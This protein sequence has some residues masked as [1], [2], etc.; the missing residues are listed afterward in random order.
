MQLTHANLMAECRGCVARLPTTPGGRTV[1]YLPS[2]HIADRWSGHYQSSLCLGFEITSIADLAQ[3]PAVLADVRPT[4]FGAVPRVWE[5]MKAALEAAGLTDPAAVP[6]EIRAGARAKLGLDASEWFCAGAAPT[7]RDV[8]EF[9]AALGVPIAELY[10]MS[11]LSCCATINPPDAIRLGTCGPPI[12][13]VELRL[14]DD[15]ELLVRGP[16][17]MA[18]YRGA[19]ELTAETIDDDGW[20]HTGDVARIDDDGYLTIIDRKKELIINAA[21]KNMS[22]A[23]IESVLKAASPI[24]GQAVAIGD[25]RPY[26]VALVVLDPD[27]AGAFARE[28]GVQDTSVAALAR[29]PVIREAVAHAVAAANTHLARVE[30]IKR[31]AILDREWVAGGPELTPTMKLQ[32]RVVNA[33][34]GEIIDGLYAASPGADVVVPA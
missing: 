21:G 13:G 9:F 8:L 2:A 12:E 27:A 33:R 10:G 23:N 11:E 15:G 5:K 30:Q 19:P 17:V 1:S 34:Y 32:R 26:N 7:T 16:T 31:C 4:T 24:I 3:L 29:E 14:E 18:G 25:R 6:E 28:R 20:L 22:P